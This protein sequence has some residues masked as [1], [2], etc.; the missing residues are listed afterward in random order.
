MPSLTLPHLT[1][2]YS[3]YG[4]P[5]GTPVLLLH[6]FPDAPLAWR[7]LIDTWQGP[8]VRFLIPTLRGYGATTI[9]DAEAQSGQL[10][11][12]ADDALQFL[13]ALE[14]PRALWLGHDWGARAAY[15]A[16]AL[17]PER[18]R[19]IVGLASSY[20]ACHN[21]GRLPHLQE[22]DFWYQWFFHTPQGE[23]S[24]TRDRAGLCRTLW[25]LWSPTWQF[26][27]ADLE[28][29]AASWDNPQFIPTVLSYYRTRYGNTPGTPLYAAAEAQ[30]AAKPKLSVPTWFVAGL[31]D[32]CQHPATSLG[33]EPWFT[34]GYQRVELPGI[35][36]F[37]HRE[38]P[39]AVAAVLATALAETA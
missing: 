6:G 4:D 27:D 16:A 11:A 10:A 23:Q 29:A 21:S 34:A 36:H 25:Q 31:A 7:G 18:F 12:L 39:D 22:R 9:T 3:E 19:A 32:G 30:L 35:G 26:T 5:S 2:D 8:P 38:A 24:L 14:I 28:A 37:P 13:Q 1:I 15:A 20:I 33:E 17:Q